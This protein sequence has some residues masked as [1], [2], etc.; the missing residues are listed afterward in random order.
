MLFFSSYAG[1]V[2]VRPSH[3]KDQLHIF[4]EQFAQPFQRGV[5][6]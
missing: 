3:R 4:L 1:E 5:Q 2:P 6:P